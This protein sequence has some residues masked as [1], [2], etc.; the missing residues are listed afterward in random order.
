MTSGTGS[1]SV[2]ASQGGD[3]NYNLATSVEYPV[4]A[5]RAGQSIDFPQPASPVKYQTSFSVSPVSTS[6]LPVGLSASGSC[7]NDGFTVTMTQTSGVCLLMAF[8]EGSLN[9]LPAE[10]VQHSVEPAPNGNVLYIP[11]VFGQ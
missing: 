4:Q 3:N 6:G 8:Q 9:Y 7:T 10:S 1:C 5:G 11:L 2:T